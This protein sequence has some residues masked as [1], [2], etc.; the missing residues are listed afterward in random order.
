MT[1]PG[2]D[3]LQPV[4]HPVYLRLLAADLA[5]RGHAP[6]AILTGTRLDW[7]SLHGDNRFLS[8]EQ[9]RR[10]IRH[11]IDL[12]DCPWL[13]VEV[14]SR[15]HLSFHGTVGQAV[16][17]S[18]SVAEAM[19]LVQ[20]YMPLRQRLVSVNVEVA[21][22]AV[23]IVG[24]EHY[25]DPAVREN[26]LGYFTASLLRLL[27]TVTGLGIHHDVA[28][29]WPFPEPPWADRY[30]RIAEQSSFGHAQLR[31][32]M[33]VSLLER[34]SLAADPEALR[35]AERECER[36]LG[37]HLRGGT[38]SLRLQ[39]RLAACR[40][41]YPSLERFADEEHVSPRTLI[42]RLR[43]E[44]TSYQQQIDAVREELACWLL[45]QTR[46]SVEA[47]STRL[48][49]DDPSNFSRTFRRWTGVTPRDFRAASQSG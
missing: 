23:L 12:S 18:G 20:R 49:Y 45:L 4:I 13:G 33:S 8:F 26:L 34:P 43:A 5:S 19:H 39:R 30:R 21:G 9:L 28:I 36:Q 40:G 2:E 32:R 47:I 7:E 24:T 17:A 42:R 48:G 15:A 27:E 31:G 25:L 38:L 3:W 44:G 46:E 1:T 16:A 11:A 14:G 29:E 22:D 35:L 37:Q 41:D 6:E 10:F